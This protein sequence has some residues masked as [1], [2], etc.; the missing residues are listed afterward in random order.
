MRD[1]PMEWMFRRELLIYK[2]RGLDKNK[3][4][5]YFKYEIE[6]KNVPILLT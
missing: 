5:I 3:K 4:E 6:A 1:G 2:R